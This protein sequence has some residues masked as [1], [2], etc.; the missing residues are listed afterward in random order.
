[1]IDFIEDV[2]VSFTK[3]RANNRVIPRITEQTRVSFT[4]DRFL[5]FF[6]TQL[7]FVLKRKKLIEDIYHIGIDI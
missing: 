6:T 4:K 5:A 7:P 3:K 2:L 1:M